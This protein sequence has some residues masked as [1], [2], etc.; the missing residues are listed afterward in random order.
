MGHL[1][2][3]RQQQLGDIAEAELV[4]QPP[5]HGEEHEVRR[6]LELIERRA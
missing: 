4:A 6:V 5:P 1:E 2:A 3:A